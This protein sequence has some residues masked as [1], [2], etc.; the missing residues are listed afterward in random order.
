MVKVQAATAPGGRF[1]KDA[2]TIDLEAGQ[3]TCPNR[4]TAPI[5]PHRDGGG[6]ADFGTA[7]ATCPLAVRYATFRNGR[8][9]TI[10]PHEEH[11]ARGRARGADPVWLAA[12]RPPGPRSNARSPI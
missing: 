3:V 1:S 9:V 4:V 11:L 8:V 10:G 2:L 6:Q 7:C 5:R 12:Y